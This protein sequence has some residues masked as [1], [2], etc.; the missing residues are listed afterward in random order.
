MLDQEI[1]KEVY[2]V[3]ELFRQLLN[4]YNRVENKK[5]LYKGMDDLTLIEINTLLVI[6][7]EPQAKSMSQIAN[8]LGVSFGTPTVTIDRLITKGYVERIRDGEDRRQVFVKLSAKGQDVY[9]DIIALKNK[10]TEQIFGILDEEERKHLI[11]ILSK[12]L[13]EVDNLFTNSK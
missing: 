4:K 8:T 7:C 11:K 9:H 12:I 13:S 10:A 1:K 2:L 6:G 5:H 3:G